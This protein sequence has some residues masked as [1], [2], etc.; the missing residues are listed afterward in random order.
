MPDIQ[1]QQDKDKDTELFNA[2]QEIRRLAMMLSRKNDMLAQKNTVIE[3]LCQDL[4]NKSDIPIESEELLNV[5]SEHNLTKPKDKSTE[6]RLARTKEKLRRIRCARDQYGVN[7]HSVR[8]QLKTTQDIARAATSATPAEHFRQSILALHS[9]I[10][11][12]EDCCHRDTRRYYD[13]R[14]HVDTELYDT[15]ATLENEKAAALT[16]NARLV[17]ENASLTEQVRIFIEHKVKMQGELEV[18]SADKERLLGA[19]KQVLGIVQGKTN[20]EPPKQPKLTNAFLLYAEDPKNM[21]TN[22]YQLAFQW[23]HLTRAEKRVYTEQARIHQS[24]T[25]SSNEPVVPKKTPETETPKDVLIS[26]STIVPETLGDIAEPALIPSSNE[27]PA[28]QTITEALADLRQYNNTVVPEKTPSKFEETLTLLR[29][30]V[31][32]KQQR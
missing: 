30:M 4:R 19:L 20:A 2:Q 16:E 28:P 3:S 32:T 24:H 17:Q 13:L 25:A 12:L 8:E 29:Q 1:E 7:L 23:T 11:S 14:R 27:T 10:K 15:I 18:V 9:R 5:I 22:L 6:S 21:C 31:I 26:G